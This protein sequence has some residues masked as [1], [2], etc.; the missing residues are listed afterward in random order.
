M[1]I[2][3]SCP[4]C[5]KEYNVK[6]EAAGKKFKCKECEAIVEVPAVGFPAGGAFSPPTAEPENPF[7][8]LDIGGP[9]PSAA[10]RP[11]TRSSS[12]SSATCRSGS[13]TPSGRT[14]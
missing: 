1:P 9:A 4:A 8:N 6:D 13:V 3:V 2:S 5:G 14:S 10:P 7:A 12:R 11:A